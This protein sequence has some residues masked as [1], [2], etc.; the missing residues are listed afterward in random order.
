MWNEANPDKPIA[1]GRSAKIAVLDGVEKLHLHPRA[2]L[3]SYGLGNGKVLHCSFMADD[4][5]TESS[6]IG[7]GT[8]IDD[9]DGESDEEED[10][11]NQP[12][13]QIL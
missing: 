5:D 10:C 4:E 6:S 13:L 12:C 2:T 8:N 3:M 1:L 7:D 11:F 9:E